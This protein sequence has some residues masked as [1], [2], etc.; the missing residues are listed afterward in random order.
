MDLSDDIILINDESGSDSEN[1]KNEEES[2]SEKVKGYKQIL[3]EFDF[4]LKEMKGEF[5]S[6]AETYLFCS[7]LRLRM[8]D[9]L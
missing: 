3:D 5:I 6:L 9:Q 1:G 8:K 2:Y 7:D 4:R